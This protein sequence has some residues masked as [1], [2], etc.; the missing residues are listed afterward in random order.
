MRGGEKFNVFYS[1]NPPKAQRNWV[2]AE[3]VNIQAD[4]KNNAAAV[5][6]HSTYL[7]VPK[8]WLGK[9]FL[10][11]AEHLKKTKPDNYAHEYLGEVIGTGGTVFENVTLRRLTDEEVNG[12]D[13]IKR[14]IDFGYRQNVQAIT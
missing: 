12:F 5:V 1:Y 3:T 9:R 7:A 10:I 14:G 4:R 11:E 13:C 2:N 6:H 8:E